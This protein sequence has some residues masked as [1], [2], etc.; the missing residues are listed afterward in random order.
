MSSLKEVK[1]RINSVKSTQ[2]ITSAMQMVASAKLHKRQQSIDGLYPYQQLMDKIL[3]NFLSSDLGEIKSPFL[4]ER[5]VK[6]V[7]IVPIA[8]NTSLCGAF[9]ANVNRRFLEVYT[10][11]K[12]ELGAENITIYPVGRKVNDF[13]KK[14]EI[15]VAQSYE[16]LAEHLAYETSHEFASMLMNKF[17]TKEIDQVVLI[18]HHFKMISS[19]IL[20][21]ETYLPIDLASLI[22]INES[23]EIIGETQTEIP[24]YIVEPSVEE[25]IQELIPQAVRL[26]MHTV[27]LDANTSEHA[28]R[29]LAMQM[30]TDNAEEL[31]DDLTQQYNKTRQ[32]AIT[33]ELLDIIGGTF[34]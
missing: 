9:N 22:K 31:I 25:F 3:R 4:E 18:Y 7:A 27:L 5:E 11:Y 13:I 10:Q 23:S 29:M 2:K 6:R 24:S 33:N 12:E 1:N 19:Q 30:A 15:P 17:I 20:M 32:Q 8:S 14:Q 34:K 16:N 26:K 21:V 28:A